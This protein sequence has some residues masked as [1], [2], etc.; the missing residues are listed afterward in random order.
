MM[1][2]FTIG[3]DVDVNNCDGWLMLITD[4][5]GAILSTTKFDVGLYNF[6]IRPPLHVTAPSCS[7][8]TD[9]TLLFR[10]NASHLV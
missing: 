2:R 9:P 4:G 8:Q 1:V 10:K 7:P 6:K 5:C 3:V